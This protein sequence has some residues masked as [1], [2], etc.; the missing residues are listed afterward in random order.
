VS[1]APDEGGRG[2]VEARDGEVVRLG[3]FDVRAR[4]G[5]E[6]DPGRD[7]DGALEAARQLE[8][9]DGGVRLG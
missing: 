3:V 6:R 2:V 7:E 4:R 9:G 5:V 8:G 1:A